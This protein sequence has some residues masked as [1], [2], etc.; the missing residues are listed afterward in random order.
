VSDI[1]DGAFKALRRNAKVMFG[2]SAAFALLNAVV[3][4]GTSFVA[5]RA[6]DGI[7]R[8]ANHGQIDT[9]PLFGSYGVQFAG[10]FATLLASGLLTGML[11][12]VVTQDVLGRR[13][14]AGRVWA[15]VR[16]RFGS[17]IGLALVTSVLEFLGLV[18]CIAPGVWLWGIW[19]VAIPACV[20]E[21]TTLGAALGRSRQLVQGMFW[22]VWGIRAL[23]WLVAAVVSAVVAAPFTVLAFVAGG[24]VFD[25][26]LNGGGVP[27]SFLLISSLG[28]LV[29][30]TIA[31][32]IRA[33][34][35]AL[36][37]VDLRMRREGLDLA[38]RQAIS[39]Q[40]PPTA[41]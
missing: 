30:G 41:G 16:P 1:L 34:V 7:R 22:R 18:A 2:F 5:L 29:G 39:T 32:P 25:H 11:A 19:A 4:L 21:K 17:L 31:Q 33:G 6:L 3:S 10:L 23:G 35:D 24:N 13:A 20:V 40:A 37:Y 12:V 38:L 8:D 36:L 26:V 27:A 14:S 9:G 28:S 15:E